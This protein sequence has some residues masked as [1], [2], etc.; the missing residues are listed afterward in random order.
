[1]ETFAF[2]PT[3]VYIEYL[4]ISNFDKGSNRKGALPDGGVHLFELS[5]ECSQ[6]DGTC[7]WEGFSVA[8][9]RVIEPEYVSG[10]L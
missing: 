2:R 3:T 1:M 7:T 8:L 5:L 9:C 4:F 6:H 10:A